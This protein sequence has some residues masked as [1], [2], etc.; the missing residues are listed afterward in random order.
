M[1]KVKTT[2][3]KLLPI[4]GLLAVGVLCTQLFQNC[5]PMGTFASEDVQML[6]MAS[7]GGSDMN[8]P[9]QKEVLPP[10]QRVQLGNK[11][12]VA[13]LLREVFT[14]AAT[15]VPNLEALLNQWII[16][17]GAQFGMGCDPYSTYSARDCG[18]SVTNANLPYRADA[19][20]VRE[21]FHVQFCE[22]VL[23]MDQGVTAVLEK[24]AN[25]PSVPN[26]DSVRQI[27]MLFYRA[28]QPSTIVINSLLDYDKVLAQGNESTLDRWRGVILQVCESP[29]WQL[30]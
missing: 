12:Y 17:R 30:L 23:G 22:N 9:A 18:G 10:T 28:D 29:G 6:D 1:M 20:T 25:R 27:Y 3:K 14:S 4:F 19:N 21:S 15:P 24:I 2:T 7:E 11:R 8:H 5:G 13:S 26:S 16:N